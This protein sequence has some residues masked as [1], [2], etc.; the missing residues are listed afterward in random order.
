M[1][2]IT[3]RFCCGC[4]NLKAGVVVISILDTIFC[5][6][7]ILQSCLATYAVYNL[8]SNFWTGLAT[9]VEVDAALGLSDPPDYADNARNIMGVYAL[10]AF[11]IA[12]ICK[13]PRLMAFAYLWA[14]RKDIKRRALYS[15]TM[16]VTTIIQ[17]LTLLTSVILIGIYRNNEGVWL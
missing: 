2:P 17:G 8:N 4:C 10:Y 5:A 7:Y 16:T 6:L 12:D 1:C 13:A 14:D 9:W 3:Y 11:I 15:K